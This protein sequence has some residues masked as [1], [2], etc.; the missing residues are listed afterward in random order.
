MIVTQS[1]PLNCENTNTIYI[2]GKISKTFI[3]CDDDEVRLKA[4]I[5]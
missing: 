2:N 5:S 4:F 1:C 3:I